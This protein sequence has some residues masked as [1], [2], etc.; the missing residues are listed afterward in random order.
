MGGTPSTSPAESGGP[1]PTVAETRSYRRLLV[2]AGSVYLVW[3]FVVEAVLPGS[4]NPAASRLAVVG[5]FLAAYA[6]SYR[7]RAVERHLGLIFT[8]CTWLLTVHYYYLFHRNGADLPWAVGAYVVVFAVGACLPSRLSLL[9][10]ST[11]TLIL[12]VAISIV[13]RPLL[14][15]IFLP[16]LVTMTVLSNFALHGRL[17]LERERAERARADSARELAEAGVALRDEFI[18][19]ASHELRTP[20]AA[21]QLAVQGLDRAVRRTDGTPKVETLER[22]IDICLRQTTRLARLVDRLLDASQIAAGK[23]A[24][25][26]ETLSLLE[27]AREVAQALAADAL[28]SGS[29]IDV[30]GDVEVRGQWDRMRVEQVVSNLVRNAIVFGQGKPIVVTVSADGDRARLSVADRGMGIPPEEQ[31]R[32]FGRFERAVSARNYG[33]MGLGLYVVSQIVEAHGGRVRVDSAPG[34]GATFTVDLP[35]LQG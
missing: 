15:T 3:W 8:A 12:G 2:V 4:F 17:L 28:R 34:S 22:S 16:G 7:S 5:S 30:S 31:R 29:S 20:L 6:A 18:A 33:G 24:L 10:Y 1:P 27:I 26:V 11:A 32:I 23:F 13:D 21:L 14:R 35:R 25:K 9:A 19:I